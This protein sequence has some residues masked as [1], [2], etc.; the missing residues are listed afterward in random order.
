MRQAPRN[1]RFLLHSRSRIHHSLLLQVSKQPHYATRHHSN[2]LLGSD[3]TATVLSSLFFYLL[4]DPEKFRR[5]RAEIDGFYSRGEEITVKY[6]GEMNYLEAC[7]HE[8][9]RLSPP[10]PSGSQRSALH[11]D[12]SRGKMLGP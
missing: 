4:Q 8:A 3:T 6:F 12:H 9:L 10:V 1:N 11:P 7:I 2:F 5:L